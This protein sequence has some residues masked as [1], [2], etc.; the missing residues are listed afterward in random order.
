MDQS[1]LRTP[2]I[3]G[4]RVLGKVTYGIGARGQRLAIDSDGR[5]IDLSF[6]HR[7][8]VAAVPAKEADAS[9]FS[10][11]QRLACNLRS[12]SEFNKLSSGQ[13]CHAPPRSKAGA[14]NVQVT[15]RPAAAAAIVTDF[16]Y[17]A[18]LLWR[19]SAE[20]S[21][22]TRNFAVRLLFAYPPATRGPPQGYLRKV[23]R[24]ETFDHVSCHRVA[25]GARRA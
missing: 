25:G 6:I 23:S 2:T 7:A 11:R 9:S 20:A 1:P 21:W 4:M 13:T 12:R 10:L 17:Q 8:E 16:L 19:R 18:G 24:P 15:H 14:R 5:P 3:L 22:Q